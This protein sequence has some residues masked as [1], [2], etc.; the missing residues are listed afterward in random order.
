M[1]SQ[2]KSLIFHSTVRSDRGGPNVL[3]AFG[4]NVVHFIC[5]IVI[6]C[7]H[8]HQ[9]VAQEIE[10]ISFQWR[11]LPILTKAGCN[12]G[13][14]H[15]AAA[16]R[17]EFQLSLFASNPAS[18]HRELTR[19]FGGRRICRE[20]PDQSLI[21]LKATEQVAHDGGCRLTIG[22]NE[23]S[24]VLVWIQQGAQ[25]DSVSPSPE[26][27]IECK[28][29]ES[30]RLP[31][32]TRVVGTLSWPDG[33][34][35]DV[36]RLLFLQSA[37]PDQVTFDESQGLLRIHQSGWYPVTFRFGPMVRSFSFIVPLPSTQRSGRANSTTT[38]HTQQNPID[39]SIA[40][41]HQQ[42]GVETAEP[43]DDESFLRRVTLDLIGRLPTE[44]E[45]ETIAATKPVDRAEI[46]DRLLHSKEYASHWGSILSRW[47]NVQPEAASR[48]QTSGFDAMQFWIRE[49]LNS[50]VSMSTM[51]AAMIGGTGD[52]SQFG[53]ANY[54]RLIPSTNERVEKFSESMMGVRLRCAN[55]HQHPFDHWT[56]DDYHGLAAIFARIS[57]GTKITWLDKG[58]AIH[59]ATG[60]A[61]LPKIPGD[62]ITSWTHAT[63]PRAQL[64]T[65]ITD[66]RNP[67]FATNI[68]NRVWGE[69]M[70]G[71]VI[72][73]MGD[74][75][76][77]NPPISKD[78]ITCL[79]DQFV[80]NGMHLRPFLRMIVLSGT[81][82]RS[83]RAKRPDAIQGNSEIEE[84][85]RLW[86]ERA[87]ASGRE[88]PID[89]QIYFRCVSRLVETL[90]QKPLIDIEL[91]SRASDIIENNP[92][93]DPAMMIAT[94]Q[95]TCVR[96]S[97]PS[98]DC[99]IENATELSL[100]SQLELILGSNIQSR[101]AIPDTLSKEL[102]HSE[103]ERKRFID[104]IYRLAFC[105]SPRSE[106]VA[107]WT[108]YMNEQVK[109]QQPNQTVTGTT[110]FNDA[111][112]DMVWAIATSREFRTNH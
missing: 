66:A 67:Y 31:F 59:P 87:F 20:T 26:L 49:Q 73:P 106:E 60:D 98:I 64:A 32:E 71:P 81:Y 33:R 36:T 15:G 52:T 80:D 111:I 75:R 105:R 97:K 9:A 39:A 24:N 61:A 112:L 57:S 68:A 25:V 79:Q 104:R 65:W 44:K 42:L 53:P 35:E 88:R 27:T 47:W 99:G 69:L 40:S 95:S 109:P 8:L 72:A 76:V 23:A 16:G 110:E 83:V 41:L 50:D 11:V 78:L 101:I 2:N 63:D 28:S 92:I 4:Q 62:L 96:N 19:E 7:S 102:M 55:C 43:I 3:L 22:S 48:D 93:R 34:T 12:S 17:G 56:Q 70:G 54:Y 82:Q 108:G 107:F 14:C 94:D 84:T 58:D 100:R 10:A 1:P 5:C 77:T 45:W 21:W 37:M 13:A 18:D 103:Q 91:Y 46:V 85:H 51:V 6:V 86:A 29:I 30:Q 74:L 38:E 90:S 89:T